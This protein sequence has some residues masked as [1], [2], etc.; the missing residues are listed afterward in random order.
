MGLW[1]FI[2]FY[3]YTGSG[4]I[5][6]DIVIVG[7]P[8]VLF[9]V[10]GILLG[11]FKNKFYVDYDYTQVSDSLRFSKVI[12]NSKRTFIIKFDIS[13]IEK[14]GEYGFGLYDKYSS[15]PGISKLVL[16]SNVQAS[17][18]KAFYYLVANVDG[19][20]KLFI[21][22]CTEMFIVNIMK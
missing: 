10:S 3:V 11:K 12:K 16:T 5:I 8:L 15:M 1:I 7:I 20:K 2:V 21:V 18:G 13:N 19:E 4:K 14:I 22:E 9:L 17:E 6:W